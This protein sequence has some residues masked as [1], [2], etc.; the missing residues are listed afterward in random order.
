MLLEWHVSGGAWTACDTPP[1]YVHGVAL[2][3][4]SQPNICVYGYGGRLHLQVGSD[5]WTLTEDAPRIKCT[6][7]VASFGLRRHFTVEAN[8]GGVLFNHGYWTG[9][10]DDFFCWLATRARDP[11]WRKITGR[12]WS[13]GVEAAVV[14]SS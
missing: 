8:A 1:A 4:A 2:I 9:Q 12:R 6:R 7:G 14:R 5:Q 11:D 10:G 13:E 3:R